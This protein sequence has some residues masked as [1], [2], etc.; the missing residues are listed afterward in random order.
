MSAKI[1][2]VDDDEAIVD[3]IGLLLESEGFETLTASNGKEALEVAKNQRPDGIILDVMMPKMSGYMVASMLQKEE[4]LK[5]IPVLLLTAAAPMV[6]SITLHSPTKFRLAKP[7]RPQDLVRMVSKMIADAKVSTSST[8]GAAETS[9]RLPAAD[10]VQ[11][12]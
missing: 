5:H 3:V 10:E 12:L 1:L 8:A 11:S 6:G 2:I 9:N 4:S 7:F